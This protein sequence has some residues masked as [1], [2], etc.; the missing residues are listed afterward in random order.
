MLL[1]CRQDHDRLCALCAVRRAPCAACA[2]RCVLP[3][4]LCLYALP[5]CCLYTYRAESR[6]GFD[7][8][9]VGMSEKEAANIAL[10]FG[11]VSVCFC[12]M[13]ACCAIQCLGRVY[14]RM[15]Q[16]SSSRRISRKNKVN[17][18]A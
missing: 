8:L 2:M 6:E 15:K 1:L 4:E 18:L 17:S 9:S 10:A 3:S 13:P 5:L 11:Q 12:G 7:P 16:L 14:R